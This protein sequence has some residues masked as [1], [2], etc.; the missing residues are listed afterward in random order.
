MEKY[1]NQVVST[2][3]ALNGIGF[4]I[5]EKWIG[6]LL[7]AGLS[8][9]YRPMIMALENSGLQITGDAVKTKLLQEVAVTTNDVAF[10]T[11]KRK[12][13]GSYDRQ[14]KQCRKCFKF[15]HYAQDCRMKFTN[16]SRKKDTKKDEAFC[17]VLSTISG[18]SSNEWYFD[19]AATSHLTNNRA[20]LHGI[21]GTKGSVRAANNSEMTIE[22]T[23]KAVLHPKCKKGDS[24]EVKEVH[25]LPDLSTNLLSVNQMVKKG[26]KVNFC[27]RG[28]KVYNRNGE[29][30]ATGNHEDDLFKLDEMKLK[31]L[32]CSN[33]I[34]EYELWHK[35]MG[36]L[37]KQSLKALQQGLATGIKFPNLKESDCKTCC[38]GKQS[39]LPF[40]KEGSRAT[41]ILEVVHSDFCGP[42]EVQSPGGKR[43]FITFKDD[44]TR[45]MFVSFLRTKSECEV[46][47]AFEDFKKMAENQTDKKIK[48][49][50]T[51]NGTE[52][53]NAKMDEA[54]KNSGI[55]HQAT[56]VYTPEQNGVSE[57]SN[58]SIVEKARCLLAEANLPK[59][60]WAEAVA[61]SVYLLNR[62]PTKGTGLTP[63]EGWTGK[64]PDLSNIRVFGTTVMVHIPKQKRLKWDFKAKE[65]RMVG[66]DIYTKGYRVY[67]S[68]NKKVYISRDVKFFDEGLPRNEKEQKESELSTLC[69][70]PSSIQN[71]NAINDTSAPC[72]EI[73]ENVPENPEIAE[74]NQQD[75]LICDQPPV[76]RS[77]RERKPV[78]RLA[79]GCSGTSHKG[80]SKISSNDPCTVKDALS[81][82][83]AND[84]KLAMQEEYEALMANNTWELSDIPAGRKPI[85]CKWIFKTKRNHIG[86]IDRYK[87]R[88]VIKGYSQRMGEDYDETYAPV[89]RHSSLRYLFAMAVQLDLKIEQMDAVTAFLQG[90][91]SEEI[92]M[93]QPQEFIDASNKG[94]CCRLKKALYGLKQ[95]SRVWNMK[96]DASLQKLGL[97]QSEYDTCVY[98]KID[99]KKVLIIAVYVD[100][101]ILMSNDDLSMSLIKK[102]LHNEFKMK[103]L[104]QIKH[105]LGMRIIRSESK[106][107]IDQELYIKQ[108]LEKFGMTNCK[109]VTT[110][111]NA[112]EKISK[113]DSPQS[114]EEKDYMKNVPYQEAIGSLM[115][116]AQCTRPDIIYAVN[117]LSRYNTN[118]GP[119][120]WSAVKH[121]MRYLCGTASN[122]LEYKKTN[123]ESKVVG[124]VDSD[125]AS[126]SDDRKSTTGYMFVAQGA[127]V[128]WSSKKQSTIALSSCEAEYMALS[129]AVQ[130][131]LWWYGIKSQFGYT[132][133]LEIKCDNQSAIALAKNKGFNPRTKHIDIRHHFINETL[134]RGQIKVTYIP[135]TEQVAD[136]LTKPLD[137]IKIQKFRDAMG[138]KS[139][140]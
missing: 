12:P 106:I 13:N 44:K 34:S 66:I 103:E 127:A 33:S 96:L 68:K 37:N 24:I 82:P 58:R 14:N 39:R 26:Y 116:L 2:A 107:T 36:H 100:D 84:W 4:P 78:E 59:T 10:A 5:N 122:K 23:G 97:K 72:G 101:L 69:L 1:V 113:E 124:F 57:R 126:E 136:A 8:E 89:V 93:E 132:E 131:A 99:G 125:W 61:Y 55:V 111:M 65:S 118:P 21:E 73:R 102:N 54:L 18:T 81:R 42:M 71:T 117:K 32:A 51:D 123:E 108:V 29:L 63:E 130:E 112:S 41:Q 60:L 83:D 25:Y 16:K 62:S 43:Y 104:G 120:H 50:R 92:Y 139:S 137:R 45:K 28:V 30:V 114:E 76:R 9:E 128:S 129:N 3:Q 119:K 98:Y 17:T 121:L 47:K 110:P 70:E 11:E 140:S 56:N 67:D 134:N 90:E 86:E 22:G 91:L 138:I 64:K 95:S 48:I 31:A 38:L 75:N 53:F 88:L 115:Y 49:L 19:S 87:A 15:G 74:V 40:S 6:A 80:E 52:Y 20:L 46:L 105:C 135:T 109:P 94:K 35:R 77:S 27:N 7:L 133:P 85:K 79:M